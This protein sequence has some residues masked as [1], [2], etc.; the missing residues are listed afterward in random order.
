MCIVR[1][2]YTASCVIL[3]DEVID[4][5]VIN[6]E[7]A[8]LSDRIDAAVDQKLKKLKTRLSNKPQKNGKGIKKNRNDPNC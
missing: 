6:V 4:I 8:M 2:Y 7:C 5:E 1:K 3:D